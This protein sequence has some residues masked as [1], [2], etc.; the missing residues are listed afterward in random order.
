MCEKARLI[1]D[2]GLF[3]TY[4][5]LDSK[6]KEISNGIRRRTMNFK[7]LAKYLNSFQ[8]VYGIPGCD[9]AVY[10][11]HI[12]VF[13]HKDGYSDKE[14]KKTS[15]K[16]L[17]FMQSAAKLINCTAIMQMAESGMLKLSDP[18]S[19]YIPEFESDLDVAGLLKK[20]SE[21]HYDIE[22]HCQNYRYVCKLAEKVTGGTLRDYVKEHILEPLKMKHTY[23]S[24]NEENRKRISEQ[25][26]IDKKGITIENERSVEDLFTKNEGCI[27][28]TVADYALFAECLCCRG[29]S[30]NGYVLLSAENVNLM[31]DQIVHNETTVENVFVSVGFNGGLVL[32]DR[33]KRITIVYAQHVRNSGAKQMEIYPK[34]REITYKC[35]GVHMWSKGFNVFP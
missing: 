32:I 3:E 34:I 24:L 4:I 2:R 27:I 15:F 30:R 28:M 18:I 21:F 13:R 19:N 5:E 22:V 16:D 8:K 29:M 10:H 7:A 20:Y 26:V 11:N 9:C 17:Y 12:N 35:L 31:M 33:E 14:T 1:R 25:Y 23:F 6:L